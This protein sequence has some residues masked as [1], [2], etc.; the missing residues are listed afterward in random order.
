MGLSDDEGGSEKLDEAHSAFCAVLE[1]TDI[2]RAPF[3][4]AISQSMIGAVLVRLGEWKHQPALR[5]EAVEAFEQAL[6][7]LTRERVP[8]QWGSVQANL[9]HTLYFASR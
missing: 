6:T 4:W 5:H 9:G 8:R 3:Q 1:N 2:E 7:K